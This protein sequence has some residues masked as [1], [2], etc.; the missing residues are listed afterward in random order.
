MNNV[1]AISRAACNPGG[2]GPMTS[3]GTP[4]IR[5]SR[6]RDSI[7]L[8]TWLLVAFLFGI[9]WHTSEPPNEQS[10]MP[11]RGKI[12]SVKTEVRL[13]NFGSINFT[14]ADAPGTYT[15]S[16]SHPRYETMQ[17]RIISGADVTVWV[18]PPDPDCDCS[19]SPWRVD[20]NGQQVVTFEQMS[21]CTKRMG[22]ILGLIPCL[23]SAAGAVYY[24]YKIVN[25]NKKRPLR[26]E[27]GRYS[28]PK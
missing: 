24:G 27:T 2:R 13:T 14:L 12:A 8:L 28:I 23:A 11:I 16:E 9:F 21:R 19:Q 17:R 7:A 26:S 5:S 18:L 1:P 10:L 4:T 6:L 15:Y 25:G 22:I 3:A 20:V